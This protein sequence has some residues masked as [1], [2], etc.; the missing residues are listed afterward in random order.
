M[1]VYVRKKGGK[2]RAVA[3]FKVGEKRVERSIT[4]DIP[5]G[6]GNSGRKKAMAVARK[7]ADGLEEP[8]TDSHDVS[9]WCEERISARL[10]SGQIEKSTY[11]GYKTSLGYIS[12]HFS[13]KN[14]EEVTSEDVEAFVTWLSEDMG[15]CQ[16]TVKK[17]Y[18]VLA[19]C[20]HHALMSRVIK[21]D[22]CVAVRP[23][24][25]KNPAPNPLT[26]QS[27]RVFVA[28]MRELSPTPEVVGVWMA[29]FTGMRRGEVCGLRWSDV[30]M[31]RG[32]D[33]TATVRRSIG[34]GSGGTYR[35]GTKSG[36]ERVVPL[37]AQ[38]VAIL[39]RR[40]TE[41]VESCLAAGVPFSPDLYVLGQIDGGYLRPWRLTK[42][43]TSHRDDW[44]LVGTQGKPPVFH[45]LRHTY[46]TI[47]VRETDVRTAQQI[48]GH[49]DVNM[50]MRYADTPLEHVHEAGRNMSRALDAPESSVER[51]DSA[52]TA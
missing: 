8:I 2:W 47:V 48:M 28:R 46:A 23:P 11:R 9:K 42:W 15:L 50:T 12:Q 37:P 22:P 25:Q 36:K 40:R 10:A 34:I 29:Y 45:D 49:S 39:S 18:N 20:M 33:A 52:D 41:M 30:S 3:V 44:G 13:G 27:R 31:P 32:G 6:E 35:K 14:V 7:W 16:N 38:L 5:C 4:T 21:W 51:F 43:W 24:R 17:T 1:N 26:E 19:S